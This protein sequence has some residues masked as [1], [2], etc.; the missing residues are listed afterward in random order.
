MKKINKELKFT[1]IELL[2]VIAIIAILAGLLM[3]ALNRARER[4]RGVVCLNNLKQIH[5]ALSKYNSVSRDYMMSTCKMG[6]D[7]TWYEY[8]IAAGYL[9]KKKNDDEKSNLMNFKCPADKT[10][11]AKNNRDGHCSYAYNSWIGYMT[12]DGTV[13]NYTDSRRPWLKITRHNPRISDTILLTEKWSCFKP[14]SESDLY[15]NA[16]QFN[17][18]SDKKSLALGDKG[19]HNKMLNNL[20]ADGHAAQVDF[21]WMLNGYPAIW[22]VQYGGTLTKEKTNH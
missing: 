6:G 16:D 11:I 17:F 7:R 13:N 22:N 21:V 5:L 1:L 4:A 3:P 14:N 18:F 20:Y 9:K 12:P 10:A 15:E 19:A 8:I 2:I